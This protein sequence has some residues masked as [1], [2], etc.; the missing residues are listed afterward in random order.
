M[1][2]MLEELRDRID[3]TDRDLVACFERRMAISR[4]IA[5]FKIGRGME[6][7]DAARER[8]VI[9][10]AVQSADPEIRPYIRPLYECVMGAS[11]DLQRRMVESAPPRR[12]EDP[13][14]KA[15]GKEIPSVA[16]LGLPGSFSEEAVCM[17]FG[18]G[19][20]PFAAGSFEEIAAGVE[21][22]AWDLGMLPIENSLTGALNEVL[23]LLLAR[24]VHIVGESV[25]RVRHFLLGI[26]GARADGLRRAMS[27]PQPL[28][29]CRRF[30]QATGLEPVPCPSTAEAARTVAGQDDPALCAIASERSAALYGLRVLERDI[31]DRRENFTRFVVVSS[32]PYDGAGA[33]KFSVACVIAHQPGSLYRLLGVFADHGLNLLGISSRPVPE[34][35]WHYSFHLDAAGNL[36]D[37]NVKAAVEEIRSQCTRF[38]LLGN[39]PAWRE[40]EQRNG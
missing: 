35:P 4:E 10:K 33:D 28:E 26:P 15:A 27:H 34:A 2:D 29:Q 5:R 32:K 8:D 37:E 13:N 23:D 1:D 16:F 19:C 17:H 20:R 18:D 30:L 14:G 24:G 3:R 21:S 9:Q 25:L 40:N 11:R 12:A 39:Y 7:F 22:G 36:R 31:Q 38:K 6:V